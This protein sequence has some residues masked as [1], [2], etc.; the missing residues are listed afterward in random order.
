[1]NKDYFAFRQGVIFTRRILRFLFTVCLLNNVFGDGPDDNSADKVRPV[2]P[3]GESIPDAARAELEAGLAKLR[4]RI[5]GLRGVTNAW[6][7][8]LLPDVQV[9]HNAVDYALRYN[10]I[11]EPKKEI[12]DA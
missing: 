2:P 8:A 12:A 1:M 10:E 5:D 11:Y 6:V 7:K 4:E 3:P 9:L